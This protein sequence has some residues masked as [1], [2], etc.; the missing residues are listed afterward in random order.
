MKAMWIVQK[1]VELIPA[2]LK[3]LDDLCL[4]PVIP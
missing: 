1:D 2:D 4:A 3:R